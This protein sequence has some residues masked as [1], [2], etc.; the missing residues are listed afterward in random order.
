MLDREGL[1]E[2][3]QL[4]QERAQL[5]AHVVLLRILAAESTEFAAAV[6]MEQRGAV[7]I[8]LIPLDESGGNLDQPLQEERRRR[9]ARLQLPQRLPPLVGLPPVGQVVQVNANQIEL[10]GKLLTI[11]EGSGAGQTAVI[12][13]YEPE[14]KEFSLRTIG[15]WAVVPDATSKYEISSLLSTDPSYGS[16]YLNT[17][18][19]TDDYVVVLT[20]APDA[21]VIVDVVPADTRTYN[22]DDAFNPDTNFGEANEEQVRSATERV[23]V[24]LSGAVATAALKP[25]SAS[26]I[27]FTLTESVLTWD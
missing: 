10:T 11:V 2:S 24:E 23:L 22:A 13:G 9:G 26:S 6:A 5:Q 25:A 8:P 15:A 7:G 20:G 1:V 19:V 17:A 14:Y 12:E 27:C 3:L 4:H 16:T 21:D 18:P